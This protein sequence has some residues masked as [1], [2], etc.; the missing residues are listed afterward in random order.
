M[1]DY[2]KTIYFRDEYGVKDYPQKLCNYLFYNVICHTPLY[3]THLLDI[4]SGKGNHLVGFK[5]LGF[6]VKGLD[7]KKECCNALKEFDVRECNI[8]KEAFPFEDD[9]FNIVFSKSVIE[10]VFN[11]DNFFEESFRVLKKGGMAIMMTPDWDSQHR[12]FW[13]D[14]THTKPWTRKSL[15]NVMRI[16]GFSQVQCDYFRQL[17]ILWKHPCLKYL[18]DIISL[19]P[20]SLKWKDDKE[21]QHRKFIRF[22]KE[23]M[24]LAVGVK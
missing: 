3:G 19:L 18:C 24:L 9:S 2:L 11:S 21:E 5:R 23:K 1:P 15:Q 6:V 13:D 16:K 7:C 12:H 4:G 10:H 22:S 8:E 20:D 14:Y 17:P